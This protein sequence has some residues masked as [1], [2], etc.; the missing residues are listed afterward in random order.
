[1]RLDDP[2]WFLLG[3][4]YVVAQRASR[5]GEQL[6][7]RPRKAA[8]RYAGDLLDR[9]AA[10]GPIS[11]VVD[12]QLARVLTPVVDEALPLILDRLGQQ[13]DQVRLIVWEHGE[14][15]TG[16][17][18]A[19]IRDRSAAADDIVEGT[20][21]RLLGRRRHRPAPGTAAAGPATG[22]SRAAGS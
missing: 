5:A 10:S 13:R 4:A 19:G 12:V 7:R 9:V 2:I 20:V 21:R 15:L 22:D 16:E 18:V 8:G 3:G 11:R 1:V 17:L 14:D 6:S